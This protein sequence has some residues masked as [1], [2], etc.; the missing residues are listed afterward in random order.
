V[1]QVQ[2]LDPQAMLRPALHQHF[3]RLSENRHYAPPAYCSNYN[4]SSH[5]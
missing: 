5:H 4:C 3:N 1:L 2:C